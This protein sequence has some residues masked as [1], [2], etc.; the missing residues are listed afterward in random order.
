MISA[1]APRC[2]VRTAWLLVAAALTAACSDNPLRPTPSATPPDAIAP[3]ED[4]A[5][6]FAS[7]EGGATDNFTPRL[8]LTISVVGALVPHSPVVLQLEATAREAISAGTVEL[9][10]P[11]MAGMAYASPDK[12]PR[13]PPSN[14]MPTIGSWTLSALA[15]GDTWK[16]NVSIRLPEKGYYRV[17][18]DIRTDG[19]DPLGMGPY[20]IDD[21]HEQAWMFVV[22]SGGFLTREFEESIFPDRIAPQPGPFRAL[23]GTGAQA[24]ADFR[25]APSSARHTWLEFV[26]YDN[27]RHVPAE[28]VWAYGR[29]Y[30]QADSSRSTRWGVPRNG[31]VRLYCARPFEYWQGGTNLPASA[32]AQSPV[33]SS[34]WDAEPDDCG[35]TV[36][37]NVPRALYLSWKYLNEVIPLINSHF[38]FSRSPVRWRVDL[39]ESRA[40]FSPQTNTIVLG[41]IYSDKWIV[42]HEYGHALHHASLGGLWTA[43]NCEDHIINVASSYT[44]AFQ[45]GLADY[46]GS[47]GAPR[48]STLFGGDYETFSVTARRAETEGSVAA[49]LRDLIDATN[50]SSD[51]TTYPA[52]YVF[53]VFKTCVSGGAERNDV[54]DFVWCLENRVDATVHRAHFPTRHL[55]S[56]VSERATEPSSW[57]ADNIRSTWIKNVGR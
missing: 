42:A 7:Q 47:V 24:Q 17:A 43:H 6:G 26:Y 19:P 44:C 57:N 34:Y 16:R 33:A 20:L 11:T 31:L 27:G 56:S 46:A 9:V 10:L 8:D 39:T 12:R 40:F 38:A 35:D 3:A 51:R 30:G 15:R 21:I 13:Y 1:K 53:T 55:P 45:E 37:V 32:Y 28:G 18:V 52:R 23:P 48:E 4:G 14:K 54:T 29:L 5:V 25:S 50:E 2:K 36:Q 49:L 22:E 41:R